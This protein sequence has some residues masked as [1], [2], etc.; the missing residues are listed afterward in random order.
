MIGLSL[1]GKLQENC[2]GLL[3]FNLDQW[4]RPTVYLV[5]TQY[6]TE[7]PWR[8]TLLQPRLMGRTAVSCILPSNLNCVGTAGS[9]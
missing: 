5:Q 3:L 7:T 2:E 9:H 4:D 1:L 6:A 8:T